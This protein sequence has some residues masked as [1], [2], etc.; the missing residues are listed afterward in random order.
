MLIAA[1][2]LFS[3]TNSTLYHSDRV[4]NRNTVTTIIP[5]WAPFYHG[6]AS[7]DPLSDRVIIWT[8]VT[9]EEMDNAPIEVSWKVATDVDL[10]NVV[11][12]GTFTTDATRDYTV[13]VDVTGLDAGTTYYYG[14]TAMDKNSLT[15]K[16]KTTPTSDQA[17]HLKFGVVSCS[18][19][20]AGYFNAYQRLA[21]RNDLDAVIHL[22]DY[23]YEYGDGVYGDSTL[24]EARD[25]DP[26]TEILTLEDYRT[27]YSLYRLDTLSGTCASAT[28]IYRRLGRPRKCQ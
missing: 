9:P 5:E 14:F 17:D 10:E 18:N 13:K 2:T 22:G 1:S 25:L 23:I 4:E 7:G 21:R 24:F 27:R 6:V 28:P 11:Q 8:R 12:S 26:D 3:Q 15:G 20:Q 19:Y 16:T